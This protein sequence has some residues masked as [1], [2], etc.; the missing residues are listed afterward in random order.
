M[1]PDRVGELEEEIQRLRL[2][3]QLESLGVPLRRLLL[4]TGHAAAI[5]MPD[6]GREFLDRILAHAR[7]ATRALAGSVL[8]LDA[9]AGELVFEVV[10]RGGRR[11]SGGAAWVPGTGSPG[12]CSRLASPSR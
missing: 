1:E 7:W 6:P 2:E 10:Q 9:P 5:S 12:S 11:R 8:L 3:R 4:E